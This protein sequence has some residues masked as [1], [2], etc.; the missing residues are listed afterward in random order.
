MGVSALR[1]TIAIASARKQWGFASQ[2]ADEN[3]PFRSE[4]LTCAEWNLN[5]A[6]ELFLSVPMRKI[7]QCH[8]SLRHSIGR[9]E[10]EID[11]L[12]TCRAVDFLACRL[13]QQI[14]LRQ[15]EE[16]LASN[17]EEGELT[18]DKSTVAEERLSGCLH[19]QDLATQQDAT[20]LI[21]T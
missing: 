17:K 3:V 13:D 10:A 8:Q 19:I 4:K 7:L 16:E 20:S 12:D 15:D 14:R 2:A 21:V 18:Q 11:G 5:V 6:R 9:R 1:V